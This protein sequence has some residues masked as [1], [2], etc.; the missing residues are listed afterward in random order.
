MRNTPDNGQI[1]ESNTLHFNDA[2][3]PTISD[4]VRFMREQGQ[5]PTRGSHKPRHPLSYRS[6]QRNYARKIRK[7]LG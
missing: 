4:I 6:A 5:I 3:N 1:T 2:Q 7:F